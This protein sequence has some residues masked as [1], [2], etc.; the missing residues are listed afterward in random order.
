MVQQSPKETVL[1]YQRAPGNS[2][3]KT[4]RAYMSDHFSFQ[5]PLATHDKPEGLLKDSQTAPSYRQ[6]SYHAQGFRGWR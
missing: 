1:T 2:D 4:A 3:Y 5:G 6:G